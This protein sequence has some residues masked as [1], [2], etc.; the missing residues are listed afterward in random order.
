MKDPTLQSTL[1]ACE[2]F[3]FNESITR[4]ILWNTAYKLGRDRWHWGPRWWVSTCGWINTR[5]RLLRWLLA[6]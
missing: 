5:T 4:E 3:G 6:P 2:E 1:R